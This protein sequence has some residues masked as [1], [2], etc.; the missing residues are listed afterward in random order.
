MK[1]SSRLVAR[2]FQ[3]GRFISTTRERRLPL[4][5]QLPTRTNFAAES[6]P[7]P[8]QDPL[9]QPL[10]QNEKGVEALPGLTKTGSSILFRKFFR[11]M[12]ERVTIKSM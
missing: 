6:P 2:L 9:P 8:P 11:E 4:R 3:R 5:P 7:G 12:Y 1:S 10:P